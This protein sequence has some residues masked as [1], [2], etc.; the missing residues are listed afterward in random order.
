MPVFA[1]AYFASEARPGHISDFHHYLV[2]PSTYTK[3]ELEQLAPTRQDVTVKDAKVFDI[4]F[5]I[6]RCR[7][8]RVTGNNAMTSIDKEGERK[9]I[10][11]LK[12]GKTLDAQICEALETWKA[13]KGWRIVDGSISGTNAMNVAM[14]EYLNGVPFAEIQPQRVVYTGA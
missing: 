4:D 11:F 5:V 9:T 12:D 7:A 3:E 10:S 8:S 6:E 14:N 2:V 13:G 1:A